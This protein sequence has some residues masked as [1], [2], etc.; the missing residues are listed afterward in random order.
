MDSKESPAEEIMQQ[1]TIGIMSITKR[2]QE[3]YEIVSYTS[4]KPII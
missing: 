4:E 1:L 3:K 2:N